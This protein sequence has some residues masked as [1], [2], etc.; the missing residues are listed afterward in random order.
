MTHWVEGSVTG[1]L[2]EP[3]VSGS[4]YPA[5]ADR[6]RGLL[7][8]LLRAADR[9]PAVDEP[10]RAVLPAGLLVPHAGLVYSGVTAAAAWSR[11]SPA[12]GAGA[13]PAAGATPPV[14]VLL[15]TNH[16]AA[17]L[18]G[19][20]AWPS[21]AW[22]T[23][24]GDIAVDEGLAAAVTGL[25]PPFLVDREAHDLEHSIEIQLPLLQA[26]A[27]GARIVPLSV[28]CRGPWAVDA[29]R[30][31]GELLAGRRAT[32]EPVVLAISTDMAHYPA[33]AACERVTEALL[34]PILAVDPDDLAEREDAVRS[35]GTR[36]LAC[37]MCGIEPAVLGL[38][39]LRAMGATRAVR[40]A[41][42]TSADAGGPA[43]RTVG[44]LAVRFDT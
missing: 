12:A 17:W 11:L 26:V 42:A 27:P 19:V 2:R 35:A 36:G 41:S 9:L 31:L 24:L 23:P 15:G 3:A 16:G 4:F 34:P 37:G 1:R 29:G 33:A 43:D 20:A 25:G 18:D 10:A 13:S 44:Y 5:A 14:V 30:R 6:L 21:G 38:A 40:L 32:G 22:R 28:S 8:G 7:D 39:A